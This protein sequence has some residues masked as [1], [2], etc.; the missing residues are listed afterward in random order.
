VSRREHYDEW[1]RLTPPA[2]PTQTQAEFEVWAA[3]HARELEAE[4]ASIHMHVW[5]Q[6]EFMQLILHCRARFEE[7]FDLDAAVR[8]GPEFVVVLRKQED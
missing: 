8:I 4:A 6:A 7:S 5:T 2:S 3:E 1:A